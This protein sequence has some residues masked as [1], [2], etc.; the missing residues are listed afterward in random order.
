MTAISPQEQPEDTRRRAKAPHARA[1][2]SAPWFHERPAARGARLKAGR[3]GSTVLGLTALISALSACGGGA[4][5]PSGTA[6]AQFD[7][8]PAAPALAPGDRLQFAV[9]PPDVTQVAWAVAEADGGTID[10]A[11]RYTAPSVEGDFT[12]VATAGTQR[13]TTPVHVSRRPK[14]PAIASFTASPSTIAPGGW[15]TGEGWWTAPR[16]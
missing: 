14:P 11:G 3:P 4:V 2:H 1:S 16:P 15:W 13:R 9:T 5:P 8:A 6:A 12:V 10:G 7:V